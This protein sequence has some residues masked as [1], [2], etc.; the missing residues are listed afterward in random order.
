MLLLA[1]ALAWLLP[2]DALACTVCTGGSSPEAGYT[3]LWASLAISA[4]PLVLIGSLVLWLR[5]RVRLAERQEI[6]GSV[7]AEREA[8][9]ATPRLARDPLA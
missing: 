9:A 7:A 5:H 1:A 2:A 6:R 4:L 8:T 3:F